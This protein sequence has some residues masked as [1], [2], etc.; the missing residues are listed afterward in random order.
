MSFKNAYIIYFVIQSMCFYLECIHLTLT[1]VIC[2]NHAGND[3][4][5]AL[6]KKTGKSLLCLGF[7]NIYHLVKYSHVYSLAS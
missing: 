7:A 1:E 3:K 6:L 2:K 5:L 4:C